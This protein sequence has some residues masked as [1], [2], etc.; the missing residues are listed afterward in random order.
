MR[1]KRLLVGFNDLATLHPE[2]AK[3][4]DYDKNG[5]FKPTD[6]IGGLRKVWWLCPAGHSYE[7]DINSRTSAGHGCPICAR[8]K[9]RD[10]SQ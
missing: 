6:C 7:M 1:K 4:W 2:I 10:V 5:D 3:E 9:K 8:N